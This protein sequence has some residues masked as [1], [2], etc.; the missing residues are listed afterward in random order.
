MAEVTCPGDK[1]D[2]DLPI[3]ERGRQSF[4]WTLAR[5]RQARFRGAGRVGRYATVGID[6]RA[7]IS[8]RGLRQVK[9]RHLEDLPAIIG[10]LLT[11]SCVTTVF[12]VNA[13]EFGG[14]IAPLLGS[15]V[16]ESGFSHM[17]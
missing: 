5:N 12:C 6:G 4:S 15:Q 16:A 1:G 13:K 11:R 14:R 3:W 2:E 17:V 9:E 7:R 10:R 8:T